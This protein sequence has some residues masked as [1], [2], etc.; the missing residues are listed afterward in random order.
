MTHQGLQDGVRIF[1]H[2]NIEISAKVNF[3][4]VNYVD[5]VTVAEIFFFRIYF[6]MLNF[7]II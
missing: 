7:R 3:R 6:R 1:F 2:K 4:K 5:I